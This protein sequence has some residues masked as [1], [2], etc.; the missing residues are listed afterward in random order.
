MAVIVF[1]MKIIKSK[2]QCCFCEKCLIAGLA[3]LKVKRHT[4]NLKLAESIN[5]VYEFQ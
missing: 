3:L 2:W 1:I 4:T 5:T